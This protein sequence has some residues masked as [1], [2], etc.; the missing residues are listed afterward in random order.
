MTNQLNNPIKYCINCSCELKLGSNWYKSSQKQSSYICKGCQNL[1]N[2]KWAVDNPESIKVS[3]KKY[4][5]AHPKRVKKSKRKWKDK[6]PDYM[7]GYW[8]DY[9]EH[10]VAVT[11]VE[12]GKLSLNTPKNTIYCKSCASK[13]MMDV[14]IENHA[15][16]RG[17]DCI[18]LF[19]NIFPDSI[20]VV[21]HHISD[22]FIVYIPISLHQEHLHG[23]RKQLHRD[24]LQPYVEN[25]YNISYLIKDGD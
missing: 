16:R 25:I 1:R 12:C 15:R 11:C 6:N 20:S 4:T 13:K 8:L 7:K 17:Y 18:E 24:E 22:G 9:A 14:R 19:D 21:G 23:S 10:I 5:D 3:E 2:K